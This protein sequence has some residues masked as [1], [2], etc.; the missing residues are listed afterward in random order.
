MGPLFNSNRYAVVTSTLALV[1]A[2]GG[3]T[4]YAAELI[5]SK[6]IKDG[7]VK[8][9]D[10]AKD[11]VNSRRIADGTLLVRDFKAG[12]LPA[13]SPGPAGLQ[14]PSGPQ[15]PAGQPGASGPLDLVYVRTGPLGAV[16][17]ITE[18]YLFCPEG[19][20]PTGGGVAASSD[21]TLSMHG[22]FP[23]DDTMFGPNGDPDSIPDNG[24][25][26]GISNNGAGTPI[27]AAYAVCGSATTVD[28]EYV[29]VSPSRIS[30]KK[31][32]LGVRIV[33]RPDSAMSR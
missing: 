27:F 30:T 18:V 15:G 16:P 6:D 19:L 8:R 32:D 31:T 20:S 24:W 21:T 14:G 17:G 5:T 22:S 9:A 33:A 10:I 28:Q 7:G 12:Q 29:V 23:F 13:G 25:A 4:A 26:V 11:A 1:I 3:G 2:L